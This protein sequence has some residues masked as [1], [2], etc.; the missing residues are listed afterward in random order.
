MTLVYS[1]NLSTVML[2]TV[3]Y[4]IIY[5]LIFDNETNISEKANWYLMWRYFSFRCI[6][7]Y[8]N[9]QQHKN[10]QSIKDI[11]NLKHRKPA[12]HTASKTVKMR[13]SDILNTLSTHLQNFCVISSFSQVS[14]FDENMLQSKLEEQD[15]IFLTSLGSHGSCAPTTEQQ[16]KKCQYSAVCW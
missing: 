15:M 8:F 11:T 6:L 12:S 3:V 7:V 13:G 14:P 4:A 9:S 16:C 10:Y 2:L 5:S 1:K